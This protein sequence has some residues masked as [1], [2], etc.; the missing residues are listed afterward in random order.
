M[1]RGKSFQV[2]P[3]TLEWEMSLKDVLSINYT[4]DS[5][6]SFWSLRHC[7]Y[8][9]EHSRS[10]PAFQVSLG[11]GSDGEEVQTLRELDGTGLVLVGRGGCGCFLCLG[12]LES[13]DRN[14]WSQL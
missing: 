2:A 5:W 9:F 6:T 7:L 3:K 11:L 8:R 10:F 4:L 12:V 14:R 1:G 13:R